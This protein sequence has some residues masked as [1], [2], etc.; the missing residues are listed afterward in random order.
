MIRFISICSWS[1]CSI[2]L[3]I[4]MYNHTCESPQSGVHTAHTSACTL[5]WARSMLVSM[6]IGCAQPLS[7]NFPL[8]QWP[9]HARAAARPNIYYVFYLIYYILCYSNSNLII[10]PYHNDARSPSAQIS[11][12][13]CL[14]GRWGSVTSGPRTQK[15]QTQTQTMMTR[16]TFMSL[17]MFRLLWEFIIILFHVFLWVAK[18]V[19]WVSGWLE[20]NCQTKLSTPTACA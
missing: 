12:Y 10:Y 1:V 4:C 19:T 9:R 11:R 15:M 5:A 14:T 3:L 17:W 8:P 16:H 7:R 2:V 18:W 6:S 13:T 20:L